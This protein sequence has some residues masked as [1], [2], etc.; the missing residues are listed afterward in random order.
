MMRLLGISLVL[1][2]IP[3]SGSAQG[4]LRFPA[5]QFG[6]ANLT[7]PQALQN[8]ESL[9]DQQRDN[10]EFLQHFREDSRYRKLGRAVGRLDLLVEEAAGKR[11]VA[12]C[13]ASVIAT[14]AILTNYHCVPG[15]DAGRTVKEARLRMDYLAKE[16][17]TGEEYRVLLPP[18][19]MHRQLDYAILRVEGE[20]ARKYG[21][22]PLNLRDVQPAE[23]LFL[24]H[25]PAGLP[26]RLTR[27]HCQ[28]G[29]LS[30]LEGDDLAH[31]CDTLP[32][33]SG[34]PV[35]SDEDGA[36]VG[37]HYSGFQGV[38]SA[39]THNL[40]KRLLRIAPVSRIVQG[41][42][43]A[44]LTGPAPLPAPPHPSPPSVRPELPPDRPA[45]APDFTSNISFALCVP[46]GLQ[47]VGNRLHDLLISQ[48]FQT[49]QRAIRVEETGDGCMDA[50]GWERVRDKHTRTI[51]IMGGKDLEPEVRS[52]IV[53][54][55]EAV[56]PQYQVE[57][58]SHG[59]Y[60]RGKNF[61]INAVR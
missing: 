5:N 33:S 48:G 39:D 18:V 57:L 7:I 36:L 3:H 37:L 26:K 35:F 43:P 15:T 58:T 31:R 44:G 49:E 22:V 11:F 9:I 28:A 20:L 34:A 14:D 6:R 13:T 27:R 29:R 61:S 42:V 17:D 32:G 51:F 59:I 30:P 19:E 47:E 38:P 12:T 41:I 8:L 46:R 60:A 53:R 55:V 50:P 1:L 23:A 40:A 45:R 52:T 54:L 2:G 10:F 56:F 25:H 24:I 16:R 21:T 4:D